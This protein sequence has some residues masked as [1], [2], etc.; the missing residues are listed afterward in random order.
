MSGRL[1]IVCLD[2]ERY[3]CAT[4]IQD[5][6]IAFPQIEPLQQAIDT[7]S[8]EWKVEHTTDDRRDWLDR[9]LEPI[10]NS[11]S[12]GDEAPSRNTTG[13]DEEISRSLTL[14]VS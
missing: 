10:W 13:N 6:A 9:I 8:E 3:C 14:T 12:E 4:E 11:L 7:I 5:T 2:A 1:S